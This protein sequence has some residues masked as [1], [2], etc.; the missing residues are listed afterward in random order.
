MICK[1]KYERFDC[2]GAAQLTDGGSRNAWGHVRDICLAGFYVFT[3]GPW[4][5]NTEV[6]FKLEIDGT[7]ICGAGVVA[8]RNPGTGMSIAF[9]DLAPGYQEKL[10][11]L[12][13]GLAHD[14]AAPAGVGLRI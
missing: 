11:T 5:I 12:V 1:H 7:V 6:Q 8:T 14:A 3:V 4:P 10:D 2:H 13:H 9:L